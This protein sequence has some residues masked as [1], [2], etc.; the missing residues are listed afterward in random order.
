MCLITE[1]TQI[2]DH[3]IG[4]IPLLGYLLRTVLATPLGKFLGGLP[5]FWRK[6]DRDLR[7]CGLL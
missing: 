7:D 2:K 3:F 4:V 1:Y 5:G 6:N